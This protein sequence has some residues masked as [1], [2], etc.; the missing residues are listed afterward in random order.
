MSSA[1]SPHFPG[2]IETGVPYAVC[3]FHFQ[4]I[5]NKSFTNALFPKAN[6]KTPALLLLSHHIDR[7]FPGS[8]IVLVEVKSSCSIYLVCPLTLPL[9]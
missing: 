3:L 2:L 8:L 7:V 6:L 5:T 1:T 9:T 4:T